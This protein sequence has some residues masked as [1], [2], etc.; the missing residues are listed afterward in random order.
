MKRYKS[1]LE[2]LKDQDEN[3]YALS[4]FEG[5]TIKSITYKELI[6]LVLKYE[7]PKENVIGVFA[8][9][10]LDTIVSIF[11]LAS[12]KQ[13]VLLNPDD[14]LDIL[15]NQVIKTNVSKLI[16]DDEL[17]NELKDSLVIDES[18]DSKDILFFTSGTT[19]SSRAVILDEERLCNAT[20]N[21]GY[22]LPL[23][24]DDNLLSVLPLSH[25]YGFVCS[26]LWP[27][28][29]GAT[30]SLTRGLNYIFL[31]FNEFGP[32][33]TTL[34]P[35]IA[36]FLAMKNLFN[37]ELKLIL[38][39]AGDCS[40]QILALIKSLGIR[41]SFGYGLTEASSGI[42]LSIG[43]DPKAM[44]ICPDYKVEIMPDKEIV[45]ESNTT[46]M[47]GY[48]KDDEYTKE[49]LDGNKLKTG[50]LGS[51]IDGKLHIVGRKKDILVLNDGTKI[52][53]PEYEANIAKL[54]GPTADFTIIQDKNGRI[55]LYIYSQAS[56]DEAI[57]GFN[58]KLSRGMRISRVVY[59]K[60]KLPR[61]KT[62][63]V[64]KYLIEI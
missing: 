32:T 63:K 41:V 33:V 40:D 6:D 60:E 30:V 8:K 56:V 64:K 57:N 59:A 2:L 49:Y 14:D 29:F 46:L 45:V 16:G 11:A 58:S 20:Y 50:D 55:V 21:G 28:S 1:F 17:E 13:L 27:L 3:S 43:D 24:S 22:C 9:T 35:Q 15:R 37:P 61:T 25:V 62:N 52:F 39:G 7:L 34:V 38:I 23:K 42:A 48:Y 47:K 54:I 31:D 26:L 51:I 53:V 4:F 10:D 12:K 5:S 36:G 18:V 19:S 44:T